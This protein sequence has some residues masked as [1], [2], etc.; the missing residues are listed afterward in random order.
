[1]CVALLYLLFVDI[2]ASLDDVNYTIFNTYR[3][4]PSLSIDFG[5]RIRY[6]NEESLSFRDGIGS[7]ATYIIA[8]TCSS[9][10]A[11]ECYIR[12]NVST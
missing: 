8:Y 4:Q 12:R 3:N 1:M 7:N 10:P 2:N 9:D 5:A 11:V 6:L